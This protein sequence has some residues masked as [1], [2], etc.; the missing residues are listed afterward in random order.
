LLVEQFVTVSLLPSEKREAMNTVY[1]YCRTTDD[2][3]DSENETV[4]NRESV[5]NDWEKEL[6]LALEGNSNIDLLN[7]LGKQIGRFNIPTQPF[8]DLIKGMRMDLTKKRR[9]V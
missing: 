9:I 4:E 6:Q 1:A 8:F 7:E 5:L 3:V 2:I